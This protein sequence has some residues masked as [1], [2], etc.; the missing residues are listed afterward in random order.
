[1]ATDPKTRT[2]YLAGPMSKF[3]AQDYNFPLFFTVAALLRMQGH[4]VVNPAELDIREGK[5]E[6][7]PAEGRINLSKH[8]TMRDAMRRDV[9][10]AL[11]ARCDT[12]VLLPEWQD[13]EGAKQELQIM[14]DIFK[15]EAMEWSA[16]EKSSP[17][18]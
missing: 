9:L 16:M 13:S 3:A 10:E 8:F 4:R 18:N 6:W 12:I 15:W 11:L 7:S 17:L 2:I 5:A 14:R 1:M